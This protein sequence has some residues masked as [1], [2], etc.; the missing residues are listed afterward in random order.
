MKI[1]KLNADSSWLWEIN[2]LKVLVDPW[3][4]ESQVDFH[5]RFSTQYHLDKQPEVYDIPRPD[6]IFISHP[7]T[8]H[9]DRETLMKFSAEIPVV[10]L[11]TIQ[12]KMQK[13][14]HFKQFLSLS[15]A[16]FQIEKISKTGFLDLVHH[17]YLISDNR[18]TMCYA[19]HGTRKVTHAKEASVLLATVTT[20][21]LPFYLGGTV[22]LGLN[23]AIQLADQL[24]VKTIISTHDEQKR[25][26]GI[27]ARLSKRTYTPSSQFLS[28]LPGQF[29]E[30]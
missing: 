19:P 15:D 9:C 1:T 7:F 5:P 16:P 14:K 20:Y 10:C 17:A 24:N 29:F 8:D 25:Q 12:R 23:K 22:N 28:L 4:S 3:F 2:G 6:F 18:S 26:A 11:P 27:V 13:W 21:D 30:F